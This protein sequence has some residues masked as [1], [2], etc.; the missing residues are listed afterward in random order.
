[1][2]EQKEGERGEREGR[3]GLTASLEALTTPPLIYSLVT[4]LHCR[5]SSHPSLVLVSCSRTV[6]TA[7]YFI[8][9]AVFEARLLLL[10]YH[11]TRRFLYAVF[12]LRPLEVALNSFEFE[13]TDTC[14]WLTT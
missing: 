2:R 1:M 6:L 9:G 11:C 4:A 12:L 7:L 14:S 10:L 5:R 13:V 8:T 3:A